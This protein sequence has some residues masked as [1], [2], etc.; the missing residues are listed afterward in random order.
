MNLIKRWRY[1]DMSRETVENLSYRVSYD[2]LR[3]LRTIGYAFSIIA[4]I[5]SA[6]YFLIGRDWVR[7]LELIGFSML[8]FIIFIEAKRLLGMQSTDVV[9][10]ANRIITVFQLLTLAEASFLGLYDHIHP[11]GI[12]IA[13]L[14]AMPVSFDLFPKRNLIAVL[15]GLVCFNVGSFILK[16]REIFV[17]DVVNTTIVAAVGLI[18]AWKKAKDKWEH[19]DATELIEKQNSTLY[20]SSTTDPLTGLTNR[21]TA[22]AKLE[23]MTAEAHVSNKEIVCLIMDVDN[24][25]KYNDT[26]GHPEGDKLLA[27][28]GEIL[29]DMAK[30]YDVNISR[31]GGEEFMAFWRPVSSMDSKKFAREV[32]FRVHEIRHP[33][34]GKGI[35]ST[36]SIGIYD[37]VPGDTVSANEVYVMADKALYLAKSNGRDRYEYYDKSNED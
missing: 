28:L 6:C 22:F 8:S 23:V 18:L 10:H 36:V 5:S 33:D 34:A 25:K 20:K 7:G 24:F 17:Y 19:E 14:I 31:I 9:R 27:S 3:V 12:I 26:Y 15:T 29:C 11:A 2:N 30:V 4:V 21:R 1:L 32:I 37:S 35:H 16:S 13:A